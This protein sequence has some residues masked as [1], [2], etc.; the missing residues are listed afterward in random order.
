MTKKISY[1]I[2]YTSI[3][4][5]KNVQSN[6]NSKHGIES[7]FSEVKFMLN[8]SNFFSSEATL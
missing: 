4:F 7:S 8:N 3:F 1:V 5:K 6:K 2:F